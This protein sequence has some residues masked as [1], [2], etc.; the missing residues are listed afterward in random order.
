MKT[1]LKEHGVILIREGKD[2]A[3]MAYKNIH[4]VMASQSELVDIVA[5]FKPKMFRMAND[6]S[7]ED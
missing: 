6:G 4:T 3:P 7:R 2:E 5:T 1:I